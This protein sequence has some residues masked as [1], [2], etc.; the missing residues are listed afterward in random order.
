MAEGRS[1]VYSARRLPGDGVTSGWYRILPP[2][3]PVRELEGD[4]AADWVVVGAGFA[5]LT[6][7][8]RLAQLRAG[9]RIVVL[10][11]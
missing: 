7:A 1:S 6:A 3:G 9:E 11:G 10:D 2:P 8:R 4:I 5:G